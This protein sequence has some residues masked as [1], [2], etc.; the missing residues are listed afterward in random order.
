M[1]LPHIGKMPF[2]GEKHYETAP[3]YGVSNIS[4]GN[5]PI[6]VYRGKSYKVSQLVCEAF[7]GIKPFSNAVVMHIDDNPQNNKASNLKWGTQKENLNSVRF[8][9]Y[10]KARIAE[11]SPVI[12]GRI[13][14][15]S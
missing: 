3:S 13:R 1:I 12:K 2:G 8:I 7:K 5:R 4:N 6:I 9:S 14:K 15:A 11:N 10:C